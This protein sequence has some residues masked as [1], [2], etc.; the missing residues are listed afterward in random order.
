MACC[1]LFFDESP[2]DGGERAGFGRAWR[3]GM[4]DAGCNE[5]ICCCAGMLL[6]WCTQYHLRKEALGGDM[7]QYVC[8]QGYFDCCCFTAGSFGERD[9]PECC[10]CVESFCCVHFATQA[11]RFYVMD[12]RQIQPD[13]CDNQ[14]VR[15]QNALQCLTCI[16]QL[17][18]CLTGSR[19]IQEVGLLLRQISDLV[20]CSVMSCMSAQVAHELKGEAQGGGGGGAPMPQAMERGGPRQAGAQAQAQQHVQL[21]PVVLQG[22]PPAQM[23]RPAQQMIGVQVPQGVGPGSQMVV[24]SPYTGQQLMVVVP[25]GMAPGMTFQV[26][27]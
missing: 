2:V 22:A 3:T 18:G 25:G 24:V 20:Y 5:P 8:C 21:Q 9:S 11:T 26:A 10:L 27:V 19:D 15:C 6:P 13:P 17:V 14:I 1:L 7:S 16:V 12:T 4:R 23:A